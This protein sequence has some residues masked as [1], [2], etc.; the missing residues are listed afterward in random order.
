MVK[1]E[2]FLFNVDHGDSTVLR[3]ESDDT[4][5][6]WVLVDSNLVRRNN[7]VVNP[8]Y[9]FLRR[10]GVSQLDLLIVTHLHADHYNG[11][12]EVIANLSIRKLA[13]PP[14]VSSK[15]ATFRKEALAKYKRKILDANR[16]SNG[17]DA[18]GRPLRSLAALLN[19]IVT[20]PE[21][22]EE[23]VGPEMSLR[24]PGLTDP[25]LVVCLPMRAIKGVLIQRIRDE[26]FELD[27]FPAMNDA[28]IVVM[29]EAFGQ[30][31]LWGADSTLLQWLEHRHKMQRDG[32]ASLGA[33]VLKVPHH[34]SKHNSEQWLY[35]YLL[36][37]Q[38]AGR[39]LL[40][41]ANGR[42]HPHPEFFQLV[43][44]NGL[45]V[46]CT[47]LAERCGADQ[48]ASLTNI[49]RVPRG[50]RTFFINY[51]AHKPVV[52]C[53]GDI[54]VVLDAN[55]MQMANSTGN[56]CVYSLMQPRHRRELI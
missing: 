34:A 20:K 53:Q 52:P 10:N 17:E 47:N 19:L 1:V 28:S 51:G 41:S 5:L 36:G 30:R 35:E 56:L 48:Y 55:G 15:S 14:F 37:T 27:S 16:R 18:V 50:A 9:E 33:S 45:T 2:A 38:L 29:L 49:S 8:A 26:H 39:T 44:Q 42:S 24:I 22:V 54:T 6:K 31:L 3:I 40:V 7:A 21:L 23:V 4:S 25:Q 43:A 46:Y 12:D 13:I 11:L 32:V